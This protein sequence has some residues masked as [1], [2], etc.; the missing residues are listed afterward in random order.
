[1]ECKHEYRDT[2]FIT[3]EAIKDYHGNRYHLL[4]TLKHENILIYCTKCGD[5]KTIIKK[6][7]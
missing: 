4:T 5:A 1:M 6:D 2:K 7:I 3:E